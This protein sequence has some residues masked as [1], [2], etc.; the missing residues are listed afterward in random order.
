MNFLLT[1]TA[2]EE[3]QHIPLDHT[4][5][6]KDLS[7]ALKWTDPPAATGSYALICADP[8]APRGIYT[9]WVAYNIPAN[10]RELSE[11]ITHREGYPNGTLQGTN[12]F[13]RV[14]Y[15]GPKPPPGQSH[16]YIFTL[17]ALDCTLDLPAGARRAD[18]LRALEGHILAEARLTGHYGRGEIKEIPSDP[19]KKKALQDQESIHSPPLR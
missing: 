7:P 5:D 14:G 9:H 19:L 18:L 17:Y 12:D 8:D 1:S 3:G 15:N 13:G 4:A 10:S 11:G 2:F 6:G 16:R